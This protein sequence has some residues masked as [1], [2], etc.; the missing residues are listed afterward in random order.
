MATIAT[1]RKNVEL[2]RKAGRHQSTD[3]DGARRLGTS[4][5]FFGRQGRQDRDDISVADSGISS[6]YSDRTSSAGTRVRA[7]SAI[8]GLSGSPPRSGPPIANIGFCGARHP[9]PERL[10][11]AKCRREKAVTLRIL[12]VEEDTIMNVQRL[13]EHLKRLDLNSIRLNYIPNELLEGLTKLEKLDVGFNMLE[14]ESSFPDSLQELEKLLELRL[15]NNKLKRMPTLLRKLRHLTRLNVGC[16]EMEE[17]TGIEKLRRMICL[18]LSYNRFPSVIKEVLP[19]K[20][21]EVLQCNGN[22]ITEIPRDI[23]HMKNLRELDISDNKITSLPPEIFLLA[24]LEALNASGNQIQRI[25]SLNIRGRPKHRVYSI[26]LSFN[27]ISK[28]PEH[29]LWMVDRL[30]LSSNKIK[31]LQGSVIKKLDF[32]GEQWL[33]VSDN[34][35]QAPP[36]DVADGGLRSIIQ[37]FREETARTTMYQGFR[38]L[39][40]GHQSSGKTSLV[41]SLVDQL[42]RLTDEHEKTIGLEIFDMPMEVQE[43]EQDE[44][45]EVQTAS[46]PINVTFWDT[47]GAQSYMFPHHVLLDQPYLAILAFNLAEYTADKFY[48]LIG[49]WVDW[50]ISRSNQINLLVVGTH[51]DRVKPKKAEQICAD[52]QRKLDRLVTD[53]T[54]AIAQEIKRITDMPVIS[55][56]LSEYLKK[57]REWLRLKVNIHSEVI[58]ASSA[59][60]DGLEEVQAAIEKLGTNK[61]LFPYILRVV[62]TLWLDVE[63]YVEEK[64]KDMLLPFMAWEAFEEELGDKF[65]MKHLMPSIG[66]YLHQIGKILWWHEDPL[67]KKYVFLR[68]SWL[69]DVLRELFRHDFKDF[70]QYESNDYIR[71]LGIPQFKFDRLKRELLNEG[72]LERDFVKLLLGDVVPIEGGQKLNEVLLIL[73]EHFNLLYPIRKTGKEGTW[74]N[75]DP[76]S[77]AL[78]ARSE[79]SEAKSDAK[80]DKSVTEEAKKSKLRSHNRFLVPYYR[81]TPQSDVFTEEFDVLKDFHRAAVMYRFPKYIPPGFFEKLCVRMRDPKLGLQF[82]RHWGTGLYGRHLDKPVRFHVSLS[83]VGQRGKGEADDEDEDEGIDDGGNTPSHVS[84]WDYASPHR[85]AELRLEVRFEEPM[86]RYK[87]SKLWTVLFTMIQS[88]EKMLQSLHGTRVERYTQ[89]P[90]CRQMAFM[91]EWLTPKEF[92]SSEHKICPDCNQSVHTDFL[93]QPKERKSAEELMKMMEEIRSRQAAAAAAAAASSDSEPTPRPNSATPS[94]RPTEDLIKKFRPTAIV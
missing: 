65:G 91:G 9:H 22:C 35:L 11:S 2:L 55:P 61:D 51:L 52:V 27:L 15:N 7:S 59:T 26:D 23:R 12:D 56:S 73:S 89:C 8:S 69:M 60:M 24:N 50:M 17:I 87:V 53:H 57:C 48:A 39:V 21:L 84:A 49:S 80:S 66:V 44:N 28:F 67:L 31:T 72:I 30:D 4:R 63:N 64:G 13:R 70:V 62:P 41:Q 16:N 46:R 86:E 18:V 77:E 94:P 20:R 33:D 19:L 82:L 38:A 92:Q 88:V 78:T 25:P 40:V 74:L 71:L 47:C 85:G 1:A 3:N 45:G 81:R 42:P 79:K 32:E 76:V 93:V 54:D 75:P 36:A 37:F 34:P 68:P 29:L 58:P 90:A 43:E 83:M 14:D 6:G 10:P 5:A